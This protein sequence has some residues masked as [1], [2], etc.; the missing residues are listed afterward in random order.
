MNNEPET[1]LRLMCVRPFGAAR[2]MLLRYCA[3]TL[4]PK[5]FVRLFMLTVLSRASR[6][7]TSFIYVILTVLSLSPKGA[8]RLTEGFNPVLPAF[9]LEHRTLNATM[10]REQLQYTISGLKFDGNIHF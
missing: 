6:P 5:G 1:G 10:F 2:G 7:S 9:G 4:S 3:L 8:V